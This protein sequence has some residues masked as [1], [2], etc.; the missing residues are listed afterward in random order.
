MSVDTTMGVCPYEVG[1]VMSPGGTDVS[2]VG[3]GEVGSNE[4]VGATKAAFWVVDS[5]EE[6]RDPDGD[7]SRVGVEGTEEGV[8]DCI[9]LAK[10]GGGLVTVT[11]LDEGDEGALGPEGDVALLSGAGLFCAAFSSAFFLNN[12]LLI[13][14][15]PPAIIGESAVE[16]WLFFL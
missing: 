4:G 13:R 10:L 3:W 9:G 1:D 12:A 15:I 16:G 8:E 7:D 6:R 2:G 11:L 5:E 14:F